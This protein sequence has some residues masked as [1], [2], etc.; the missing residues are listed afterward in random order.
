MSATCVPWYVP[1]GITGLS[2]HGDPV[3]PHFCPIE[4]E[5]GLCWDK[6]RTRQ[7][8]GGGGD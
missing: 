4:P 8:G 1:R 6:D 2:K 5:P 7:D 3:F